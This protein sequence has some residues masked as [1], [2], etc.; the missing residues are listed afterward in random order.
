M[1]EFRLGENITDIVS[2]AFSTLVDVFYQFE[3][4]SNPCRHKL[5]PTYALSSCATP[6]QEIAS[7]ARE[8]EKLE[9]PP[10]LAPTLGFVLPSQ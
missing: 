5:N 1:W 2:L 4:P 9:K 7:I 3:I 6:K 8:N 10:N